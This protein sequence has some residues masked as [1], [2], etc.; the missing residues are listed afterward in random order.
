MQLAHQKCCARPIT[1]DRACRTQRDTHGRSEKKNHIC[2]PRRPLRTAQLPTG[3][4]EPE[5]AQAWAAHQ[6]VCAAGPPAPR[7]PR[8]SSTRMPAAPIIAHR[9]FWSS[10]WRYLRARAPPVRRLVAPSM[11]SGRSSALHAL[12]SV[13]PDPW[14]A[15]LSGTCSKC[16]RGCRGRLGCSGT[17]GES[18]GVSRVR[19]TPATWSPRPASAGLRR[20]QQSQQGTAQSAGHTGGRLSHNTEAVRPGG[21]L[22]RGAHQS[23]SRPGGHLCSPG[24]RSLSAHGVGRAS[25]VTGLQGSGGRAHPSGMRA[26]RSR[27]ATRRAGQLRAPPRCT[28]GPAGPARRQQAG[29]SLNTG[30]TTQADSGC[31]GGGGSRWRRCR[32]HWRSR[33]AGLAAASAARAWFAHCGDATRSPPR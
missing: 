18:G 16:A 20:L 13:W 4:G 11:R 10:A 1:H 12:L 24:V 23:Q 27:G 26:A 3:M 22:Q 30:L 8:R 19:T 28:Y 7:W 5:L 33:G 14:C 9:P 31:A 17:A 21:L 15:T 29:K 25:A 6:G 32:A 2:A